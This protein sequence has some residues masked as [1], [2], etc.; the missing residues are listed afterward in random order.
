MKDEKAVVVEQNDDSH[1]ISMPINSPEELR[2]QQENS[3][4]VLIAERTN[5]TEPVKTAG[6]VMEE[7]QNS[8]S[9]SRQ[10]TEKAKHVGELKSASQQLKMTAAVMEGTNSVSQINTALYCYY[11]GCAKIG[12][13]QCNAILCFCM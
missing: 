8:R 12:E 6:K 4:L 5:A 9:T 2:V 13:Y 1:N 7:T 3:M 11:D 10:S